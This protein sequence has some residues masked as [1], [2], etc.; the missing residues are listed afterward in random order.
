MNSK[1]NRA[2]FIL[3]LTA[4]IWGLAFVA[5]RAGMENIEPFAFNGIRF[6]LGS[7]SLVPL[8]FLNRK[9]SRLKME[10]QEKTFLVQG[11]IFCGL[12]LF[13]GSSFQQVGIVYTTAGNAGFITS[14][15]VILVPVFGLLWHH[16]V[17]IQ[18]WLGVLIALM[19]LYFLSAKQD[20]TF[21]MGDGLVLIS[22]FFFAGH[23]LMIAKYAPKTNIIRLSIIQFSL[24]SLL[25]M[26]ISL[27]IETTTMENIRMAAIPI[28]YG[29]IMS[30]GV[31]YTLQV[32]GQKNTHPAHAAIILSMESLFAAI[33]G[34]LILHEPLTFP[35]AVGGT[36]MLTG[37]IL[38]QLRFKKKVVQI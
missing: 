3:L 7:L 17:N 34:I 12:F 13:A 22:A 14:L 15:Y 35:I 20:L 18:T 24:A 37:V 4:L 5:Q 38:S 28:L 32:F 27:F 2:R 23:V 21:A 30:V 25:S 31:A 6:A 29:G 11:G 33:G 1:E 10:K 36:L 19:G 26:A 16:K 8:L 9:S